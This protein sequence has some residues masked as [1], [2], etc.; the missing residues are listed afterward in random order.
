MGVIKGLIAGV[1]LHIN[2][3]DVAIHVHG[4]MPGFVEDLDDA[5]ARALGADVTG[6]AQRRCGGQQK[7]SA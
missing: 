5:V 2:K 4:A 3:S 1:D 6:Q 7:Q